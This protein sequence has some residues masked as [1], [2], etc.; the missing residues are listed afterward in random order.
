MPDHGQDKHRGYRKAHF[1]GIGGIG[2]SALAQF[3]LCNGVE[4]TGSDLVERPIMKGL[5]SMGA[6]IEVGEHSEEN[7][8]EGTDLVIYTSEVPE[9]NPEIEKAR[10]LGLPVL[11]YANV[12]G[13]IMDDFSEKVT[14]AG[15]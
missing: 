15:K 2:V 12:L 11:S 9:G 3:F 8:E 10:R 4:V 1:L 6:R 14:I 13:G 7:L 5:R